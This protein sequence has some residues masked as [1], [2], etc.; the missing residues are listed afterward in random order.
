MSTL[1]NLKGELPRLYALKKTLDDSNIKC[2]VSPAQAAIYVDV[3]VISKEEARRI[4]GMMDT[5]R[6]DERT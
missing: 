6:I 3:P 2:I 4:L 5:D 1:M